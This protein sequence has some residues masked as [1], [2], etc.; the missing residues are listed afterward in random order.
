MK[1]YDLLVI[2]AGAGNIVSHAALDAGLSVA[3]CEKYKFGGTCLTRGCIPTKIL[4]SVAEKR[5]SLDKF[6]GIGLNLDLDSVSIN[7]DLVK[8]RVFSKIDLS[9]NIPDGLRNSGADVYEGCAHF[10]SDT[11]VELIYNDGSSPLKLSADKILVATG[12]KTRIPDIEGLDQIGFLSS[13]SFFADAYPQPFPQS[14][15]ILG[16]GYI[17]CEFAS[18]FAAFG[19]KVTIIQSAPRLL[20]VMDEELSNELTHQF[21][22]RGIEIYT[23]SRAKRAYLRDNKKILVFNKNG[24][25]Y[26]IAAD[27]LFVAPGVVPNTDELGL[28]NTSLE[29]D[30]RGYIKTNEAME[31]SVPHIYCIG[32]ANGQIQLRHTANREA[33]ILSHNLFNTSVQKGTKLYERMDYS[34]I[35][36]VVFS[37][38]EIASVGLTQAE[39]EEQLGKELVGIRKLPYHETAKG[40][41]LGY[42]KG[43]D[44]RAFVKLVVNKETEKIL[45]VHILGDQASLLMQSYSYLLNLEPHE[46]AHLNTHLPASKGLEKARKE[47]PLSPR[48]K[49]DYAPTMQKLVTAHPSLAEVAA[50][51]ARQKDK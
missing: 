43:E 40:F 41:A 23:G 12:A 10:I 48:M 2:G 1:H 26:E 25:E 44:N 42:N 38:P 27:E 22:E 5:I 24:T 36:S 33:R 9:K 45:G 13:E 37:T 17:G 19:T 6:K 15:I 31:T 30:S 20:R 50:W 39:A 8:Q 34:L 29:L 7:Q 16:G 3:I 35:P 4:A 18:I 51:A 47:Q 49:S 14:L 46:V 28:E 32:D 21:K 11:C